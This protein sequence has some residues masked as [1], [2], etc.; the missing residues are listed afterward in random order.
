MNDVFNCIKWSLN[1]VFYFVPLYKLD[2]FGVEL[3]SL[4]CIAGFIAKLDIF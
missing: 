1:Y 3:N 2:K 4:F